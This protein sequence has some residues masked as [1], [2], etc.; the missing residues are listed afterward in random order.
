MLAHG[1][2]EITVVTKSK[3]GIIKIFKKLFEFLEKKR[4]KSSLF[5]REK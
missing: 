4:L 1:I 2:V 5:Y 3:K